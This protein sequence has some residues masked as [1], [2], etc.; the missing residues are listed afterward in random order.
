M[1][2]WP[3]RVVPKCAEDASLAI[4]HGLDEVFWQ[5]DERDRLVKKTP[6]SGGWRPVIDRLVAERTSQA[7]KSALESLLSSP[8]PSGKSRRGRREKTDA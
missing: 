8:A 5:K 1:H 7:V 2:L 6:P 4:A 3:E